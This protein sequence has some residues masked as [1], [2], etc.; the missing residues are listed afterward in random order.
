MSEG[1]ER[2]YN[3]VIHINTCTVRM[4]LGCV[5][6]HTVQQLNFADKKFAIS[7][8]FCGSKIIFVI[9][10]HHCACA[11]PHFVQTIKFYIINILSVTEN[12]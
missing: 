7:Q 12:S 1:R 8:L 2:N 3:K 5:H 9:I 6:V 11:E 10:Q 4:K